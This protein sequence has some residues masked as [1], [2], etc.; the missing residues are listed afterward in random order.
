MKCTCIG[1]Y[2]MRRS[3]SI[4]PPICGSEEILFIKTYTAETPPL[5]PRRKIIIWKGTTYL[6]FHLVYILAGFGRAA[7]TVCLGSL[8]RKMGRVSGVIRT[9]ALRSFRKSAKKL[10]LLLVQRY[11]CGVA[12]LFLRLGEPKNNYFKLC[13]SNPSIS[14]PWTHLLDRMLLMRESIKK[15]R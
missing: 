1:V 9:G 14:S 7:R 10:Q 3:I 13:L 8:P 6:T 12:V 11:N 4:I 5:W 2:N 15:Q